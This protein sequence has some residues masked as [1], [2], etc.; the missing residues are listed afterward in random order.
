MDEYSARLAGK[1][2]APAPNWLENKQHSSEE[3]V[4]KE[5]SEDRMNRTISL[6]ECTCLQTPR[7]VS[8]AEVGDPEGIVVSG[9]GKIKCLHRGSGPL[10]IGILY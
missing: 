1:I 8:Y 10:V 5:L 6:P 7:I 2:M 3:T 9:I 4:R